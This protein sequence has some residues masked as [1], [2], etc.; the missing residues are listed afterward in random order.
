M[1][2]DEFQLH[3]IRMLT[4][5]MIKNNYDKGEILAFLEQ[6]REDSPYIEDDIL[7]VMDEVV[8]WCGPNACKTQP[9]LPRSRASAR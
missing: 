1:T 3:S 8:G 2:N 7:D 6:C 9:S 5:T 4:K